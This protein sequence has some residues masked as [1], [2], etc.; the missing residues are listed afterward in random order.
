MEKIAEAIKNARESKKLAL[1]DISAATKIRINVLKAI[2]E[3]NFNYLPRVYMY[4]FIKE[5]IEF[6]GLNFDDFKSQIDKFYKK[7]EVAEETEELSFHQPLQKRKKVKYTASQLNKALYLIY[8]T[9]SLSFLA[10]IYF[11][12]FYEEEEKKTLEIEKNLDTLVIKS[13][14]RTQSIFPS[15]SDSI[16]LEFF[17]K[18]TVWI[19]MVI[20]NRFTEKTVLYPNSM[21][22]WSAANFFRFTLGNAG[23]VVIKRDGIELPSLSKERVA[24]KNIVVTRDKFYIETAPKP[25]PE[26]GPEKQPILLTPSEIKREIPQLRDTKK[27]RPN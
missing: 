3:G 25:K 13:E 9:I 19:N 1:E 16:R 24:I 23:G 5:Y 26:T 11:T 27:I 17:A 22:T 21:K 6:L 8:I 10:I 12:L 18:D 14:E 20:D 4:S 15:S 2:E 7:I